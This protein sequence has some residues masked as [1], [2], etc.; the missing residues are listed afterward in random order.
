MEKG[1]NEVIGKVIKQFKLHKG[2]ASAYSI[3]KKKTHKALLT[4]DRELIKL[5]K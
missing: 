2:E 1:D 3:F 4:D 5:C